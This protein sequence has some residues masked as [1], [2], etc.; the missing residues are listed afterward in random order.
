MLVAER[1]FII[2][3]SQGNLAWAESAAWVVEEI[4]HMLATGC[5]GRVVEHAKRIEVC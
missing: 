5:T 1:D 2:A 4:E 3:D